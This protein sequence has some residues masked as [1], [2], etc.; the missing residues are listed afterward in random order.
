MLTPRAHPARALAV[1]L[2][3][4]CALSV[5]LAVTAPAPARATPWTW[6]DTLTTILR[7]LPNLPALVRTGVDTLVVWAAGPPTITGWQAKLVYGTV[8]PAVAPAGGG[9]VASRNRWELRFYVPQ[10]VAEGSGGGFP[11]E[12][13]DLVLTSDQTAPDTS[14]HA[15]QL[16]NSFQNDYY[17]AQI[18][19]THL[20]SH[21]FSSDAGFSTADTS[22]FADY[23]A[24]VEDLNVIHPEFIIHTGDLVNEGE[25]EDYLSMFEM[26]RAKEALSRLRA[27]VFVSTG[28][29]DI[30]GWKPTPPPDGTSRKLWW[31]LFGWPFLEN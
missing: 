8:E 11:E 16:L 4:A 25:L 30:G 10:V 26:S 9:Y 28:N 13:Y 14:R 23:D 3:L 18:S 19:D 29:H 12:V 27:P 24:V 31:K 21:K 5:A 15:V 22:G 20:P 7:P 17:F 1:A 6:G 2:V